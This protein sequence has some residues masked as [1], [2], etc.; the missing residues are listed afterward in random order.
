MLMFSSIEFS[1]LLNIASTDERGLP[2]PA[3]HFGPLALSWFPPLESLRLFATLC[4]IIYDSA[5][6]C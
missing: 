2:L 4:N 3:A 1:I 5:F 6:G